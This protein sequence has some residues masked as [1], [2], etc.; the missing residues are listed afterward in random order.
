MTARFFAVQ[1]AQINCSMVAFSPLITTGEH[2]CP[3]DRIWAVNRAITTTADRSGRVKGREVT[4][5]TLP[6]DH[7]VSNTI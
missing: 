7:K 3:A 1:M 4:A 5:T 6:S 2:L